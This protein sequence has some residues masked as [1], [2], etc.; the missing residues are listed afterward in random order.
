M[1]IHPI[2]VAFDKL[3]PSIINTARYYP[4]GRNI[5]IYCL[6][7]GAKRTDEEV[8]QWLKDNNIEIKDLDNYRIR[9]DQDWVK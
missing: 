2:K 5:L 6:T 9:D 8:I 1:K 3:E 4:E 7:R